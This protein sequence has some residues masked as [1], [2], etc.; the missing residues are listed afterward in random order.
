[1][2][3]AYIRPINPEGPMVFVEII[4]IGLT[5]GVPER[6]TPGPTPP[7]F[8][9]HPIVIP[10]GTPPVGGWPSGPHPEHPIMLPGMPGWGVPPG[11]GGPGTPTP[12]PAD[13]VSAIVYPVPAPPE[14]TPPPTP[15]AGMPPDSVQV[16]I[17]FGAGTKPASAWVAPYASTGPVTP[18]AAPA[19][20]GRKPL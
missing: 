5:P 9:S 7:L 16:L 8:P 19:P 4:A 10:P 11:G 14:G 15:P 18:P 13:G 6:P 17:Y 3:Y 12:G 1:M 2:G 20:A